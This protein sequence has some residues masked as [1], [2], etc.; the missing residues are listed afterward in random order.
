M[1]PFGIFGTHMPADRTTSVHDAYLVLASASFVFGSM[2]LV[3]WPFASARLFVY[4]NSI[5]LAGKG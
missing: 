2:L 3:L 1:A 5:A 4:F